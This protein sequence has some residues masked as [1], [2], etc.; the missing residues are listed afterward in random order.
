MSHI[1]PASRLLVV[2]L[3]MGECNLIPSKA[4]N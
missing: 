4:I 1:K 2:S 3:D